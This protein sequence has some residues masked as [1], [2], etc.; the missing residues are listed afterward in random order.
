MTRVIFLAAG[1][2][3][4]QLITAGC[5]RTEPVSFAADV[6]PLLDQHCTGCHVAGQAGYETSGLATDSYAALMKGTKFGPVIVAGDSFNSTLVVLVEGRADPS[7]NM[8][9]GSLRELNSE[10]VAIIRRW[11]DSGAMND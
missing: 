2:L 7:I 8:P 5:E 6:K 10:E 1:L 3:L 9:H 11:I 4:A